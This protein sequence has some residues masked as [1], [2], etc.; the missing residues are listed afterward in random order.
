MSGIFL[1]QKI[2]RAGYYWPTIEEDSYDIVRKCL[3]CQQPTNLVHAP[4][5]NLQPIAPPWPFACWG[6]D[7]VGLITPLSSDGH[8]WI[9]T[10]TNYFTKWVE[11]VPLVSATGVQVS[12]FILYHII[13]YF[14]IQSTIFTD[15][16]GNFENIN[17]EE[18]CTSLCIH[19]FFSSPYFPQGNSQAEETNKTL[20]K[21]LKKVVN[22]SGHNWHLQI[23]L[24]LWAYQT[25]FHTST[26]TT[27]YSLVYGV[28]AILPIEFELPS[29][30][31]SLQR[32]ISDEEYRVARLTQL[33]L[34][35]EKCQEAYDHL[36]VYQDRLKK[37]F[38]KKV[39]Q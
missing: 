2:L 17:M 37:H 14:G 15:H 12:R 22:D 26:G 8:K 24:I 28:E 16:R 9:I 4:A 13:C 19:H 35:D 18:L 27:P 36:T 31:I 10:A 29:L 20:L 25:S 3:P 33:D 7:L 30:C 21:I 5:H 11:S 23:N 32:Q 38:N 6:L 39:L 34:L 1:A